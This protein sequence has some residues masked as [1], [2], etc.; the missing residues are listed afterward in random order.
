MGLQVKYPIFLSNF[1]EIW[2]FS[3][4]FRRITNIKF[5]KNPSFRSRNVPYGRTDKYDA[6]R[7]FANA[8]EDHSFP[9]TC[10]LSCFN[11]FV[12]NVLST[13]PTK[14]FNLYWTTQLIFYVMQIN[15]KT[16]M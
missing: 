9:Q 12:I 15:Q 6:I 5:H 11:A 16:Y 1:N 13:D 7:S 10:R 2:I 4:Y 14:G 8:P 3:T